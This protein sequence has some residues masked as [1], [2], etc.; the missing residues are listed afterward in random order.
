MCVLLHLK[1]PSGSINSVHHSP[2]ILCVLDSC[3]GVHLSVCVGV[4]MEWVPIVQTSV[5]LKLLDCARVCC[6]SP[7]NAD[8]QSVIRGRRRGWRNTESQLE[9]AYVYLT[10]V[11]SLHVS[12]KTSII[13]WLGTVNWPRVWQNCVSRIFTCFSPGDLWDRIQHPLHWWIFKILL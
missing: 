2:G 10:A 5:K 8:E 11:L 6:W 1:W 3:K 9:S 7:G 13:W 4:L 12:T